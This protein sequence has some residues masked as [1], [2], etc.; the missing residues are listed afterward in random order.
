MMGR[1]W[2]RSADD[3]CIFAFCDRRVRVLVLVAPSDVPPGHDFFDPSGLQCEVRK[4]NKTMRAAR[5]SPFSRC[6]TQHTRRLRGTTTFCP[7]QSGF[8][9]DSYIALVDFPWK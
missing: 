7:L 8:L 6:H 3:G 1:L 2:G 9:I 4:K 5:F